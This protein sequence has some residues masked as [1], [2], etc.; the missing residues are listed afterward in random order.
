LNQPH[1]LRAFVIITDISA[2]M[3]YYEAR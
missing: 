2:G 3:Q 1:R